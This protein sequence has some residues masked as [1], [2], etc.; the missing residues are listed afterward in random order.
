[1]QIACC[2]SSAVSSGTDRTVFIIGHSNKYYSRGGGA[3]SKFATQIIALMI[4]MA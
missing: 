1:L 3:L 2:V 4:T